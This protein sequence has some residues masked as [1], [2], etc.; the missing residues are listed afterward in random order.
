MKPIEIAKGVCEVGVTDW[1]IR[2]FHG[3][4][5]SGESVKLINK[6]L[7]EMKFE[8]IEP[9]VR[10]QYVPDNEGIEACVLLGK[11]REVNY[12]GFVKSYIMLL[13]ATVPKVTC[14]LYQK[15]MI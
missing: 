15:V 2:N 4:G 10:I 3:Y 12:D 14:Q 6:E 11:N 8:N 1:N 7:E 13:R 9:G 5:W